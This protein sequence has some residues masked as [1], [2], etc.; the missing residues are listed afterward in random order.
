MVAISASG[1]NPK[2]SLE[3][4]VKDA[5]P[6]YAGDFRDLVGEKITRYR[7]Q[8]QQTT[9]SVV[10]TASGQSTSVTEEGFAQS[11]MKA[12][13]NSATEYQESGMGFHN[14]RHDLTTIASHAR[15]KVE[16]I[17]RKIDSDEAGET[18]T[19]ATDKWDQAA[20]DGDM[21]KEI[22]ELAKLA[23]PA[24]LFDRQYTVCSISDEGVLQNL[25]N[26]LLEKATRFED[27]AA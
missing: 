13:P 27:Q 22:C 6:D 15:T 17:Y 24:D 14:L 2:R 3:Q 20:R 23:F 11:I 7:G 4:H 25:V 5:H 18:V 9:S 10:E 1:K 8:S 21:D 26:Y 19:I 12:A 16:A